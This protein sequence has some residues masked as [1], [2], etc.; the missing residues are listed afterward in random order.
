MEVSGQ[1]QVSTALI[2][3]NTKYKSGFINIVEW[4]SSVSENR[5]IVH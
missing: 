5:M 3:E 2:Q 4:L 1:L